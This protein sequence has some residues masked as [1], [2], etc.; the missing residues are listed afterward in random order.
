MDASSYRR[1]FSEFKIVLPLLLLWF[2]LREAQRKIRTILN[3]YEM[4]LFASCC[5]G[6]NADTEL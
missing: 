5:P 2:S 1:C 6:D 3:P 4:R